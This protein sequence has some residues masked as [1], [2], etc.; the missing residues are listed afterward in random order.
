MI[1]LLCAIVRIGGDIARHFD[2]HALPHATHVH[3][4]FTS[5]LMAGQ[6][7]H[8]GLRRMNT[9]GRNTGRISATLQTEQ[10]SP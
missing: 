4:V 3:D 10:G 8:D 1:V 5:F 7:A 6:F 2:F 9:A